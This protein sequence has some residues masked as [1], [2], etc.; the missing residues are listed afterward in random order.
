MIHNA[1]LG[2]L[3]TKYSQVSEVPFSMQVPMI[4]LAAAVMIFGILPGIPL[5]A[6][7]SVQ[8]SLGL[9]AMETGLWALPAAVGELNTVNI[10]SGVLL[11]VAIVYVIFA[12]AKKARRAD[13]FDSYGAG[14]YVPKDR[15]QYSV[16]FYQRA[17]ELI[18]PY[19]RDRVDDLYRWFVAKA[20]GF[21]EAAP[22]IYT[23]NVNT[24]VAYIWLFL[25][26]LILLKMG[27][28]F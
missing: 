10:L 16:N 15:Y 21:F 3:P 17:Y 14:L 27:G 25:A 11:S 26:L 28:Q 19:V 22:E 20:E 7:S 23:G 6:I 9:E 5:R 1:F 2:Q 12:Q 4:L 8:A 24:Y 13:Q 18:R